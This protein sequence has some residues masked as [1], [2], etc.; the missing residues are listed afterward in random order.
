LVTGATGFVGRAVVDRLTAEGRAVRAAVRAA[1]ARFVEGVEA[2]AVGGIGAA[3]DWRTAVSGI[4]AVVHLAARVHVTGDDARAGEDLFRAVNVD[5][6]TGLARAA[7]ETRVRRFVLASST[8]IYG[9]RSLGVP[10]AESSVPAPATP[11]A[12]S[13]LDGERAVAEALAGSETELVVLRPP[14]VYGPGA[15]GNFE[16]LVRLVERGVPLP[17]A[18]VRNRRSILFLGN[19][20]DAIV[21]AIDHPAAAGKTYNVADLR[22]VS[23]PELIAG[24]AAALRRR[25]RLLPWPVG[26]LRAAAALAGCSEELSRLVDDMAVDASRMRAD[27]GWAP[28]FTL[29]QGLAQSIAG[30]GG[31]KGGSG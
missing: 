23:T 12:R 29:A 24:I 28:P 15:K 6:A 19:L 20:V 21:R 9:D 10:F 26:M 3:T 4:D 5:G 1:N 8:T 14:L 27:L 18:S 25:A 22:D 11:Y 30:R 31:G 16:R 17:L 7:R 2:V 13:K